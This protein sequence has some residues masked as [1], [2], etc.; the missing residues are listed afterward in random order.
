MEFSVHTIYDQKTLTAMA[1]SLRKTIRKK[2]STRYRFFGWCLVALCVILAIPNKYNPFTI[3]NMMNIFIGIS[4]TLILL[5]E[6]TL[7]GAIAKRRMLTGTE[8]STCIFQTNGYIS[9]TTMGK[10][11]FSYHNIQ[12]FVETSNHF[13]FILDAYHTQAYDKRTLVG[14]T[15]EEFRTFLSERTDVPLEFIP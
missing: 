2:R 9:T 4:L 14:G 7:N 5:F 11:L 8:E 1:K 6:D 15:V 10:T 3:V 13:I 12:R